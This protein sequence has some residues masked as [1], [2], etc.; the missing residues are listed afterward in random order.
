MGKRKIS[1]RVVPHPSGADDPIREKIQDCVTAIL[2]MAT[3]KKQKSQ[4]RQ[5]PEAIRTLSKVRCVWE[6]LL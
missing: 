2:N 4:K 1:S 5:F 3:K 6:G